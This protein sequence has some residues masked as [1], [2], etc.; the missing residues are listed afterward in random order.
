MTPGYVFCDIY[1]TMFCNISVTARVD[2]TRPWNHKSVSSYLRSRFLMIGQ[3]SDVANRFSGH[4]IKREPVQLYRKIS[5]HDVWIINRI[6]MTAEGAHAR[7]TEMLNDAA[8]EPTTKFL[9]VHAAVEWAAV[10]ARSGLDET[11]NYE[12]DDSEDE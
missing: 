2:C 4:Y 3:G 1:V 5:M 9:D 11:L 12:R 8:P 7:Y 10:H 6:N